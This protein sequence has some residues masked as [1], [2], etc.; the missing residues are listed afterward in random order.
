MTISTPHAHQATVRKSPFLR[1]ILLCIGSLAV[2]L[3]VAGIFLP[4]LPTVPF[5]I[6][7]AACFAR[8]SEKAY[9]WICDHSTLGPIL[10]PYLGAGEITR[11]A[12]TRA[13]LFLW[14][15]LAVTGL[16]FVPLWPVRIGLLLIGGA[17]TRY[18]LRLP[19]RPA[20]PA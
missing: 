4:V 5:L 14:T 9:R 11:K 19:L 16:Y 10:S 12:R 15:G 17:V 20:P 7:A 3:G 18:L 8:S 13:I 2:A 6:L 1:G